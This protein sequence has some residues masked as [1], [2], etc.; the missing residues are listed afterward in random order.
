MAISVAVLVGDVGRQDHADAGRAR[1]DAEGHERHG[2]WTPRWARSSRAAAHAAHHRLHRAGREGRRQAAWSTAAASTA[3]GRRRLRRRLL[4]GRHA[5]RPRHARDD[6]STRKRSSARCC[7]C[8]RVPDLE[9]AVELVNAHEFGNGV[10][11]FTRDGN[12][13]REFARRIQVG[14]V[15]INVPIP[16]PMAWH[17]FGG[18]KQSLFGDMHAYGEEGVRFYTKQ[19]SIMQRWPESIGKG[20]E[21]AMPTRS[22]PRGVRRRA[23]PWDNDKRDKRMSDTTFDYIVIGAGT[24][25]CLL[26]NRLSA[27]KQQARAADR[28]RRQGRLPL[29]PHPGRL[30]LL[31]RQPAHRLAL[32]HRAR[33]R[34]ERPQPALPA[35]QD[36]GRL[37]QHQRHDLHARPGARLRPVGRSSPATTTGAGTTCCR[38]SRST[39]TTTSGADDAC[40]APAAN[41]GWRSSACAGTSSTPSRR[42]RSRPAFRTATTSTA[43][44]TKASATSRSTRRTAGA[45]TRPRPSCGRPATAARTSSCGPARRCRGC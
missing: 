15:G 16:V 26:A 38:P 35:R 44:T 31:H 12:V 23:D 20:A 40:T 21:F 36:A 37:L 28:G 10:A 11:C 19:K 7:R 30:P 13:A 32:Q 41:G 18:W 39:R 4:D 24:A 27:D 1:E 25:G 5:V 43:A 9:A 33:P 2:T 17:G 34:P 8:V 42:P 6:A 3:R 45:G 14:M 29:D 22:R